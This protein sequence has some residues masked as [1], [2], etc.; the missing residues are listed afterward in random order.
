MSETGRSEQGGAGFAQMAYDVPFRSDAVDADAVGRDDD[1]PDPV[2]GQGFEELLHGCGGRD[3]GDEIA[4]GTKHGHD[5][6]RVLLVV[7]SR[8]VAPM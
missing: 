1:R 2:P 3:G 6:H 8:L 7:G 4:F 5:Q